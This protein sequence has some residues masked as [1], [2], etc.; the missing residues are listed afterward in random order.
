M[1]QPL[2]L[3]LFLCLRYAV[4]QSV[5]LSVCLSVC[6]SVRLPDNVAREEAL[7]AEAGLVKNAINYAFRLVYMIV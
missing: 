2:S 3:Y 1:N 5:Y 4:R 7:P 6:L